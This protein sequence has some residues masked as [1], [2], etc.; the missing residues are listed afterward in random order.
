MTCSDAYNGMEDPG[1]P[2]A[3]SCPSPAQA[4]SRCY[5]R[6]Q[7][8]TVGSVHSSCQE[9]PGHLKLKQENGLR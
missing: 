7:K 6:T 8:G 2:V 4:M 1:Q 3:P 5:S 9:A